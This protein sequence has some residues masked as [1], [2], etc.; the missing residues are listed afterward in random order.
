MI[1]APAARAEDWG[2]CRAAVEAAEREAALPPACC[3]PSPAP[4]A[5]DAT[6]RPAASSPGPGR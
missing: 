5:A 4:K 3:T 1:T 2:A 6:P